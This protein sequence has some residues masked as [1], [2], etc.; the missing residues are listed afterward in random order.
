MRDD[1]E[2]EQRIMS[3]HWRM[4]GRMSFFERINIKLLV[5]ERLRER[6]YRD[7]IGCGEDL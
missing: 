7:A 5:R 2:R 3:K 6:M 4:D 1:Q